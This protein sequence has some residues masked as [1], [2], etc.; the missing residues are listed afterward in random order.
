V[1]VALVQVRKVM[2]VA[3]FAALGYALAVPL[4]PTSAQ[5]AESLYESCFVAANPGERVTAISV[6]FQNF[7]D[8]LLAGVSYTLRY[9]DKFGFSGDCHQEIEGGFLC[10]ACTNDG[11]DTNGESFTI[12]WS[13]GDSIELVND[14]TGVVGEN[15]AGGRDYLRAGGESSRFTLS[16]GSLSD[17]AW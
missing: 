3:K 8:T 12:L 16:R 15:P 13:G 1:L 17:C 7:A 5:D 10:E 2:R 11:C 4:S 14:S 9:G 6:Y